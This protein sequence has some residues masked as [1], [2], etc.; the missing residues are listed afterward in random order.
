MIYGIFW[1]VYDRTRHCSFV[2]CL[3]SPLLL[4]LFIYYL[5]SYSQP[6]SFLDD[7]FVRVILL[8]V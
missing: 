6:F 7:P 1:E 8:Q 3:F 2:I 4:L 5:L